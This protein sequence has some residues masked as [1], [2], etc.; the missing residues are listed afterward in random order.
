MPYPFV[1]VRTHL[2]DIYYKQDELGV[3]YVK[4]EFEK[5]SQYSDLNKYMEDI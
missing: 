1:N 5:Y 4:A 2:M 3:E